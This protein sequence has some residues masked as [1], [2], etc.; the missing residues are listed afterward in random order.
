MARNALMPQMQLYEDQPG[1]E[2][3]NFTNPLMK[4]LQSYSQGIEKQFEGDRALAKE[5]LQ[6]DQFG[7]QQRADSRAAESH[8]L[9]QQK[10]K[11]QHIAGVAQMADQEADPAR[12]AAIMGQ[13]YKMH[14]DLVP[15][16]AANGF[17]PN[18]HANVPKMLIAEARGFVDPQAESLKKAQIAHMEA[19]TANI[20]A[21]NYKAGDGFIYNSRTGKVEK[22]PEDVAKASTKTSLVP[23]WGQDESGNL[24]LMQPNSRG[25]AVQTKLPPGILPTKGIQKI[26]AGTHY[27][28]L[29][30]MT[31]HMIGIVPKD[32][33]GKEQQE[34]LGK[35][36]GKAEA[37]LPRVTANAER[38][39]Q[40][41]ESIRNHPGKQYG[42]GAVGVLPGVPGTQQRGFVNLVDQAKGQTFLEAFNSLRGG[43]AIT[44]TEGVKATQALA[45]LDRSQT[46]QDFDL[47]LKDLEDVVRRGLATA[48]SNAKLKGGSVQRAVPADPGNGAPQPKGGLPAGNYVYDPATGQLRQSR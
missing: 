9:E 34:E 48:Q 19:Q 47:A 8:D 45:R 3:S 23:I 5:K 10:A 24:V 46:P 11:V 33:A 2:L 28:L 39:L 26:D 21:D 12:K 42:V 41:I 1:P 44:E 7:L 31:G 16:M 17:D 27:V 22:L 36:A 32:V 13:I 20:G 4:G 38:A 15:H 37:E 14:P 43:G 6:R 40:T 25:E 29:N 30:Q 35:A 18:D